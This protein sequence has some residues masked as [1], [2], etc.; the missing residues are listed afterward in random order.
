MPRTACERESALTAISGW[1]SM[2]WQP[3][4][5]GSMPNDAKALECGQGIVPDLLEQVVGCKLKRE[6]E[7]V[8]TAAIQAR[9]PGLARKRLTGQL[10]LKLHLLG[11]GEVIHNEVLPYAVAA[12]L[13]AFLSTLR[14]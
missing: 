6:A 5:R 13:A 1:N 8:H 3:R 4:Q 2:W 14:A 10:P 11:D 12:I 9:S 7:R